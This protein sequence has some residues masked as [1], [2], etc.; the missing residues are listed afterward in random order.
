MTMETE[1]YKTIIKDFR[2]TMAKIWL[3]KC[4]TPSSRICNRLCTNPT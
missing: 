2:I 4:I 1:V 3:V